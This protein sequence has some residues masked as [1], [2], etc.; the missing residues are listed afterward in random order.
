MRR[1]EG[2]VVDVQLEPESG[3][4]STL[5]LKDGRELSGELYI[6]CSGFRGLL[7]EQALQTGYE[8][9][10][11]W[12]PCNRALAVPSRAERGPTPP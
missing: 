11:H 8:D 9:W 10:T 4:V 2:M 3:D 6:D 12:L 5:R 1:I 7:I